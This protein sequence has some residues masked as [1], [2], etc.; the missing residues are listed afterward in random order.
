MTSGTWHY[1]R[2]SAF[3]QLPCIYLCISRLVPYLPQLPILFTFLCYLS[4]YLS[5]YL[6]MNLCA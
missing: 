4:L 6:C 1:R 5:F 3:L 2:Q